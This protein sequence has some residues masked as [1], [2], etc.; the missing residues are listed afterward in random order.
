[1]Y[2]DIC[3]KKQKIVYT[4]HNGIIVTLSSARGGQTSHLLSADYTSDTCL[5][6]DPSAITHAD[7]A[8]YR[9]EAQQPNACYT[10]GCFI[11]PLL[12][13]LGVTF[14]PHTYRPNPHYFSLIISPSFTPIAYIISPIVWLVDLPVHPQNWRYSQHATIQ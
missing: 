12:R 3:N 1:M 6:C 2:I 4:K 8:G 10:R 5:T 7:S 14:M 9:F 13:Q 11:I